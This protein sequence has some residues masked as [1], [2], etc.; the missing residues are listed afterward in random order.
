MSRPLAPTTTS[1]LCVPLA[2]HWTWPALIGSVP[3]SVNV[4]SD[5]NVIPVLSAVFV[6]VPVPLFVNVP[7]QVSDASPA[8][9]TLK[10]PLLMNVPPSRQ[11]VPP[12][13]VAVCPSALVS[14][15]R[16][17]FCPPL[18]SVIPPFA[19]A[20]PVPSRL[21][22]VNVN[23]PVTLSVALPAIVPPLSSSVGNVVDPLLN[24]AV[25]PVTCVPPLSV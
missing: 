1:P 8:C 17:F 5:R 6:T 3:L 15:R 9:V 16:M 14:C 22:V 19:V 2:L 21:P 13:H 11:I 24:V 12:L 23:S 25:P 4:P 7:A 18:S 10:A 20:T